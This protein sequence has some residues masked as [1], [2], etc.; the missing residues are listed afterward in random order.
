MFDTSPQRTYRYVRIALAAA[1]IALLVSVAL[2]VPDVGVLPTLSHYFYTPARTVFSAA[3]IAASVCLLVLSGRD[4]QRGLLDVAALLAPLVALIPTPISAGE[5]AGVEV[6]CARSC[7]PASAVADVEN[8]LVSY[9][10]MAALA[11]VVGVALRARSG[12]AEGSAG[13]AA[14]LVAA[15]VLL[16]ALVLAFGLE[17]P[18]LLAAGHVV[19]AVAFFAVMAAVAVLE[20]V[21]PS[22]ER[23]PSRALRAAYLGIAAL[24]VLD[25]LVIAALGLGAGLPV[26]FS[27]EVAAL[28]LFGAFWL[29]QTGQKWRESDPSLRGPFRTS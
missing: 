19:S 21:R 9:L 22:A 28:L 2:A 29:L 15:V 1:P 12:T 17:R 6:S 23:P 16:A 11:V 24:L 8:A 18:A 10:V 26:V 5:V 27:G 4:P 7:I 25:L 20:A 3:L 14:T 13:S